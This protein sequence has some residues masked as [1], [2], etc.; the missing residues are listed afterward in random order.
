LVSRK[1][2]LGEEHAP[3]GQ[4]HVVIVTSVGHEVDPNFTTQSLCQVASG[5]RSAQDLAHPV[6]EP[7]GLFRMHPIAQVKLATRRGHRQQ[8]PQVAGQSRRPEPADRERLVRA[9]V[10]ATKSSWFSPW[11]ERQ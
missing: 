6:E 2:I 9:A 10:D 7:G 5:R 11:L 1:R 3:Y 4:A 8:M